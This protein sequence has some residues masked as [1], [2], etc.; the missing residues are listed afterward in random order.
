MSKKS[1]LF[2]T[3]AIRMNDKPL[4][5]QFDNVINRR[6]EAQKCFCEARSCRGWIGGEPDSDEELGDES[7]N[8]ED[9]S[10]DGEDQTDKAVSNIE[11][12]DQVE[13]IKKK[14]KVPKPRK[15]KDVSKKPARKE[16][17]RSARPMSKNYK[18][19]MNR[20]EIMQDPDLDMEIDDLQQCGLKNQV[21]TLQFSRLMG[22]IANNS[23]LLFSF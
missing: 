18:K 8:E 21:Q 10:D 17:A 6:K 7:S 22:N 12:N 5:I 15:P 4:S 9:E 3:I 1:P 19:H 23:C 2:N 20:S 11:E 16:R 13:M 14:I